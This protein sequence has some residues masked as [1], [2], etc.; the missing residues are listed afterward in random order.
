MCKGLTCRDFFWRNHMLTIVFKLARILGMGVLFAF[1][2]PATA[3]ELKLLSANAVRAAI[4]ELIPEFERRTGH[5]V[6]VRFE[7]NPVIKKQIEQGEAFDVVL[8]NPEFV[9]ELSKLGKVRA[10]SNAGMGRIPMGVAIRSGATK[11]RL[12]TVET[13]KA[14]MLAAKSIA[15]AGEGSSGAYFVGLM[16]KLGIGNEMKGKLISVGGGLTPVVVAKGE[17]ELGVVPVTTI[18]SAIPVVDLAGLFPSELQSYINLAVATS[19][20]TKE[21]EASTALVKFLQASENDVRLRK[22]GLERVK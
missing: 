13:F 18:I 12:D 6:V 7:L 1:A 9:D 22:M 3:A 5:K 4:S 17:A 15:Y 21:P 19:T 14:S 8:V 16:D 20:A 11:P 10:S 2:A